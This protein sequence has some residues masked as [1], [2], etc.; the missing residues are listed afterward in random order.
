MKYIVIIIIQLILTHYSD[1][2]HLV[3]K[4]VSKKQMGTQ[5]DEA[6]RKAQSVYQDQTG[7]QYNHYSHLDNHYAYSYT[8]DG[9]VVSVCSDT[10]IKIKE[11]K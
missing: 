1:P 8:I 4:T 3:E 10:L 2:P 9:T 7:S 11:G 6:I 5:I